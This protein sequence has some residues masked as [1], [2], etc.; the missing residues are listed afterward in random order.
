MP[1]FWTRLVAEMQMRSTLG[2]IRGASG[3][4]LLLVEARVANAMHLEFTLLIVHRT[5]HE[6]DHH[7]QRDIRVRPFPP[8]VDCLG[9]HKVLDPRMLE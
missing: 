9:L 1:S 3:T 5:C 6:D 2:L 8:V 7:S 4:L